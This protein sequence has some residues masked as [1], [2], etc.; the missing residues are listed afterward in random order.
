MQAT[1]EREKDL[2]IIGLSGRIDTA[3]A[4]ALDAQAATQFA[5]PCANILVDLEQV[6]YISSAGLRSILQLVKHAGKHGGRVGLFS[7]TPP[8]LEVIEI[9]GFPTLLDLYPDRNSALKSSKA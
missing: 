1:F 5:Q 6:T 7:V 2:L 9:S 3:T 8:V 4:P